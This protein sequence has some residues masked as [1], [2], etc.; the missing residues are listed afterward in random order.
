MLEGVWGGA[1]LRPR[2]MPRQGWQGWEPLLRGL[3][4]KGT[5]WGQS[6]QQEEHTARLR[7]QARP[8]GGLQTQ[9]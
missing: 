2:G 4:R 6:G 1:E 3:S 5:T 8:Q 7:A 9:E